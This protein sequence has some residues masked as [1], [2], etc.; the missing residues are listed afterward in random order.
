MGQWLSER[1]GQPFIIENRP[2]ADSNITAEVVV[3]ARPEAGRLRPLA[4]TAA[5]RFEALPDIPTASEFVPGYEADAW[6]GVGAPKN[7]P[8]TVI[9]RLNN[10]INA[11][12]ADPKIKARFGELGA[13]VLNACRFRQAHC[14]PLNGPR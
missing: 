11:A 6:W 1:L 13:A 4:V 12:L 2:G 10:E 3:N 5:T 8:A 14:P 9:D 7:T